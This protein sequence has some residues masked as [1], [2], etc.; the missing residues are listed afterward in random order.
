M[1]RLRL[2]QVD[3]FTTRLFGGNPAAVV[4]LEQWLDDA[5]MQAI[6]RENNLAETAFFVPSEP[7]FGLRWFTPEIEVKLC[8][9]A[10]LASAFVLFTEI[11]PG[12]REVRFDT[13]SGV[14][15][16]HA[17]DDKLVMDFPRWSLEPAPEIPRALRDGLNAKPL[18][19]FTTESG[20][21][22]FVVF[23]DADAVRALTP[24]LALLRTLNAGVIVT[25]PGEESDCVCRYFAPS[26]GIDEDAGTGSIHCA[27]TPYWSERLRKNT[28]HSRQLSARGAELYCELKGNRV[29]IAGRAVKYLEGWISV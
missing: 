19:V 13:L 4:P 14:L 1:S 2:Y 15:T 23:G 5:T 7:V 10:T 9:H 26:F 6:A 18:Q 20:A 27:L 25:A 28:V 21:N 8:G 3:A 12:R 24:D 16:V 11:E 22:Y 29:E 17:V